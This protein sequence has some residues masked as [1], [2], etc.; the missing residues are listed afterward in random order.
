MRSHI[1]RCDILVYYLLRI[2]SLIILDT[3]IP[4]STYPFI[5]DSCFKKQVAKESSGNFG[6]QLIS[7]I[8]HFNK[9]WTALDS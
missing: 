1:T 8:E 7:E 4:R 2:L 6:S 3:T 5:V 9:Q